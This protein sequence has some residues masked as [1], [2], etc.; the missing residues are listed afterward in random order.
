MEWI[1]VHYGLPD[2][3]AGCFRVK[4]SSGN[5]MD[6]FFY[7][8]RMGWVEY[9]GIKSSYWYDAHKPHDRLDDVTHWKERDEKR[10]DG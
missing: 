6:A 9:Y 8:D 3:K 5:E 2:C 10:K 7:A 4:R 1:D